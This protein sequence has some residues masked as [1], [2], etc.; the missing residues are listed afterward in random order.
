MLPC[1]PGSHVWLRNHYRGAWCS[2]H[3]LVSP[4]TNGQGAELSRKWEENGYWAPGDQ[5]MCHGLGEILEKQ[6]HFPAVANFRGLQKSIL[7]HFK[8]QRLDLFVSLSNFIMVLKFVLNKYFCLLWQH[9]QI[10]KIYFHSF[11]RKLLNKSGHD[12]FLTLNTINRLIFW[13]LY[14]QALVKTA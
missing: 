5:Y 4:G 9:E 11:C 6:H 7:I 3:H 2:G 8:Y 13:K 10:N 12:L 14:S 1:A